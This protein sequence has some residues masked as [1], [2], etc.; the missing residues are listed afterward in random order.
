MKTPRKTAVALTAATLAA[1][2]TLTVGGCSNLP[3]NKT[4][5]GTVIGAGGGAAAGAALDSKNRALGGLIGGLLGAGGG[6]LVGSRLDKDEPAARQAQDNARQN[7]AT[8]ADAKKADTADLNGDGFVTLDEVEAMSRSGLSDEQMI[9]RLR[10]TGQVFNLSA[11]QQQTLRSAGV[12][13]YV[14]RTMPSLNQEK[15]N[16]APSASDQ[17]ISQPAPRR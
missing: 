11:D 9:Q 14:I 16:T 7:P 15:L 1:P 13:D 17:R 12:S 2:L 5:Q 3:G 10:A 6:Y 4:Q 8:P